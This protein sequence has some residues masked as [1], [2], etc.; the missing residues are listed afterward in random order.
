MT[1]DIIIANECPPNYWV[2]LNCELQTSIH[3]TRISCR[4]GQSIHTPWSL[5]SHTSWSSAYTLSYVQIYLQHCA[6]H[7]NQK[8]PFPHK[9]LIQTM[10]PLPEKS[11]NC[12]GARHGIMSF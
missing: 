12:L 3:K 2:C 7:S 1:D 8:S 9:Q 5:T 4:S 11:H 10:L 6:M